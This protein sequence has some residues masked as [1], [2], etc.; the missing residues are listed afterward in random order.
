MRKIVKEREQ[1][2]SESLGA[3]RWCSVSVVSAEDLAKIA[4][5][6][7]RSCNHKTNPKLTLTNFH[8]SGPLL[9]NEVWID[10]LDCK[11]RGQEE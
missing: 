11:E 9:S 3:S 1:G 8:D 6:S 4:M 2:M 7:D 10:S 5:K